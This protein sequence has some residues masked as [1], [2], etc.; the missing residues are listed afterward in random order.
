ME[1]L[2]CYLRAEAIAEKGDN[3]DGAYIDR[4]LDAAEAALEA[5]IPAVQN[6]AMRPIQALRE[7]HGW[8][9]I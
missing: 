7:A 4:L 5:E 2:D 8:K 1:W 9:P 6:K 3:E